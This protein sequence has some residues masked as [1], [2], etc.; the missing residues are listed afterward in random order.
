MSAPFWVFGTHVV[1]GS[2]TYE[3]LGGS[4]YRITFKMYRDC[5]PTSVQLPNN[6][7]I[8][9]RQPNGAAFS[10]NKN[11]TMP[12]TQVAQLN[13]PIDTCAFDP[14]ICVEE[15]I[16]T[17]IVNNLPP[18]SGG[19]HLYYTTCCRNA[20][21]VNVN[22]PL[23]TGEGFYTF[24]PD[25]SIH[26][27]NSSPQWKNFTPVFVCQGTPLVFDHGATDKDGDS[28]AYSFYTPFDNNAPTFPGN[29]ATFTPIVYNGGYTFGN[30][31]GGGGFAVNPTTGVITGSPPALGQ[32][33]V[34]VQVN[35][36]RN[37]V[38]INTV[39]RDFQF[40]VIN[41]PNG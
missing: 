1:G 18:N 31:L 24:I 5:G 13:P 17:T 29:V 27:T 36:Y 8:Q 14:G 2:L 25:N 11:F 16:Y 28:L 40:N 30:P 10:P 7:T 4:T 21:L 34:G 3:H 20:S 15:A 12:K 23:N 37:G 41:C 22:D 19:Y 35:E 9:V 39:Y 38:L 26:L 6:V 33:V 32:Y